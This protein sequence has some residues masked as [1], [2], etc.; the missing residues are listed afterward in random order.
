M[1]SLTE[2]S[3]ASNSV[4]R[5]T[6]GMLRTQSIDNGCAGHDARHDPSR[7]PPRTPKAARLS[8]HRRTT[9]QMIALNPPPP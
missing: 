9:A 4:V 7:P 8:R 3:H 1:L 2:A 6:D 5:L